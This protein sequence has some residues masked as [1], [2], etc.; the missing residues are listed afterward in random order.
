M[1]FLNILLKTT[2]KLKSLPFTLNVT[3]ATHMKF[4][5]PIFTLFVCFVGI[6]FSTTLEAQ[7]L[8][9][10][11]QSQDDQTVILNWIDLGESYTY[12]VEFRNSLQE[13]D[14]NPMP[15]VGGW[16]A[17]IF[18]FEDSL[19]EGTDSRFYRIIASPIAQMGDRGKLVS[20]E[21]VDEVS[22]FQ[23][24][25]ALALSGIDSFV[26]EQGVKIFKV[27]YETIDAH[28]NVTTAS[29]Q[30]AFP[31]NKDVSLPLASYQHG[32]V[33]NTEEVPSRFAFTNL[34]SM[35]G[36]IM[37]SNGYI[38]IAPDYLGLGDS[39]GLHPY[40]VAKPTA[41]SVVDMI[42]AAKSL[43][44]QENYTVSDQLF[45]FGY[46]EGGY[47]TMAAHQELEHQHAGEF[48]VTASAPMA[49][50]YDVSGVLVDTMLSDQPYSN[51][52]YLAYILLAYHDVYGLFENASEMF[53]E[54]FAP[55]VESYLDGVSSFESLNSGLPKIPV[56]M[57]NPEF[58]ADF[59]GNPNHPV[60]LLLEQNDVYQWAPQAPVRLVHCAGDLTVPFE[61]SQLA[62]EHFQ[63][64]GIESVELIN[65]FAAGDHSQCILPALTNAK[66]W[67][68]GIKE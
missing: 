54:S 64:L 1:I 33:V 61:N 38:G 25:F 40:I 7:T 34:E 13:T 10:K 26:A 23:L 58:V 36:P 63:S 32:T 37:A 31:E 8:S 65:P 59:S 16:P 21:L 27:N 39:S 29:G 4:K 57:L 20:S 42:R 55:R 9:M 3:T 68:D 35:V 41:T 28:G 60:R 18:T 44:E 11:I 15:R 43:A 62:F 56:Q 53:S 49:G 12:T 46:S 6:V 14:W 51:P 24:N 2:P 50:P 30:V 47:A 67:F 5:H 48:S 52:F 17:R 45:L 22:A 19:E 66:T